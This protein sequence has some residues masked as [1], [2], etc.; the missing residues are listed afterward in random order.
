MKYVHKK[1][2]IPVEIEEVNL[3]YWKNHCLQ[4]ITQETFLV[5]KDVDLQGS[6]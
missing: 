2:G 5:C 4:S 6:K 1:E 3:E